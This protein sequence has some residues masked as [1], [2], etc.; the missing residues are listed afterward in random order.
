ML[1]YLCI[2][3][4]IISIS[5]CVKA[6]SFKENAVERHLPFKSF[7]ISS[8][9]LNETVD[10]YVQL[11]FKYDSE[12]S[13]NYRYPVLYSL[14]AP[15]GLPL[16]SGA[17]EPLNGYN[18]APQMIIVG[19][20]TKNR[21]RDYTPSQDI[22]YGTNSGGAD[23]YLSYIEKDVIPFVEKQFR[24]EKFRILSGHSY[25]GLLVAH[26]FH[27]KPNLFQAHF[28]SSPSIFWNN[29]Q[30]A[31]DIVEFIKKN[32]KHKNYLYMN[33]GNEG[34]PE[35]DSPEGVLMLDGIKKIESE[36]AKIDTPNLRYTFEYL[37][38][39]PHQVTQIYGIIGALRGL[40]P[41][42]EVPYKASVE[43]YESVLEHFSELSTLYG[44]KIEPKEWQMFDE[45]LG[46]LTFL[47]NPS[48]AIKYF[49]YNIKRDPSTYRSRFYIVDA[50][51]KLN[52]ERDALKHLDIL[53]ARKDLS[54]KEREKLIQKKS[55][56]P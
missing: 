48:E 13:Q 26:S 7:S 21:D 25:G 28:S 53:L 18:N 34:K 20:T 16:V 56:L 3:S 15:V 30:T 23:K 47:E 8:S 1:K 2:A 5:F 41:Q 27:K 35:S 9:V 36:F 14:D 10:I 39:Q 32:D 45:G 22:N 4:M 40:Y 51:L 50:L 44:Y 43:G 52:R 6:E 17:L 46:Q 33:I 42:W 55:K 37:P 38:D 49:D 19:L 54:E 12:F 11:P 29:G 24:T 31:T